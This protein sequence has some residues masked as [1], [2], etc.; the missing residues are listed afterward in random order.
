MNR[1]TIFGFADKVSRFQCIGIRLSK[2]AVKLACFS[3]TIDKYVSSGFPD[4]DH[5]KLL[6]VK[7]AYC[8]AKL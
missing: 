2:F 6:F 4:Y 3:W 7:H 8:F 1:E 5:V